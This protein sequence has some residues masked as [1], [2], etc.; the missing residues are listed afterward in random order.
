MTAKN[1]ATFMT[2]TVVCEEEGEFG[3]CEERSDIEESFGQLSRDWGIG[4]NQYLLASFAMAAVAMKE[5]PLP[6]T[7]TSTLM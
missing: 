2:K 3:T 1:V 4:Q 7:P 6:R 5:P